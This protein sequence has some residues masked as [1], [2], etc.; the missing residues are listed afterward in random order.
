MKYRICQCLICLILFDCFK[1]YSKAVY[2]GKVAYLRTLTTAIGN[3]VT[4]NAATSN[5]SRPPVASTTINAGPNCSSSATKLAIPDSSL[6]NRSNCPVGLRPKSKQLFDTLI[7]AK[8]SS[9]FMLYTP[10]LVK[11][12]IDA[13]ATVR[14]LTTK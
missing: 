13:L 14:A 10:H 5:F 8:A 6:L 1:I 4:R 7:P 9:L 3:P 2:F 11:I 12:R